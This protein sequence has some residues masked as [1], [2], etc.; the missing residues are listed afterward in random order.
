MGRRSYAVFLLLTVAWMAASALAYDVPYGWRMASAAI[1][2]G[3]VVMVVATGYYMIQVAPA[4]RVTPWLRRDF[5]V[6]AV[7]FLAIAFA[8]LDGSNA[9]RYTSLRTAGW[10]AL[11][12]AALHPLVTDLPHK[13]HHE[14]DPAGSPVPQYVPPACLWIDWT[15]A[16]LLLAALLLL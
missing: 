4:A 10:I 11:A 5:L 16:A 3:L 15:L 14:K 12:A 1:W 6:N 9:W 13:R 8:I 2:W 7:L